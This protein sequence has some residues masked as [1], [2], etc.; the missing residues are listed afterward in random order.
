MPNT[1]YLLNYWIN[2]LFIFYIIYFVINKEMQ[3]K[4]SFSLNFRFPWLNCL[5]IRIFKIV[6]VFPD[7]VLKTKTNETRLATNFA[8]LENI[9]GSCPF[10][11]F[12]YY[13]NF[14]WG[15]H[16]GNL[17]Y[18]ANRLQKNTGCT[19]S[20]FGTNFEWKLVLIPRKLKYL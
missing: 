13:S 1:Y 15:L 4:F 2:G 18:V 17:F 3:I 10:W 16:C 12:C 20:L 9:F 7:M 6:K 5:S 19:H 8:S 14:S 11:W